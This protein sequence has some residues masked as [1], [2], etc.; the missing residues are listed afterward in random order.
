ME[1]A[2]KVISSLEQ[3]ISAME[4][5]LQQAEFASDPSFIMRLQTVQRD[6][7]HKLYEWELLCEQ[8]KP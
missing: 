5:N 3:E 1:E 4:A 2:E 7:E 8:L 6:M